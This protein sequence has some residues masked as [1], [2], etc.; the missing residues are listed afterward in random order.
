M[1]IVDLCVLA[2]IG[3][4]VVFGLYQGFL[5]AGL[6]LISFFASW[7]LASTFY[8]TLAAW[9][10]EHTGIADMIFS[11]TQGS[12]YIQD[13]ALAN[14][15]VASLTP[16]QAGAA[17]EIA[18]T[19]PPPFDALIPQ[20]IQ[21][22]VFEALGHASLSDYFDATL[23]QFILNALCFI[24]IFFACT[25]AFW[26]VI[27]IVDAVRKLPVLKFFDTILGGALGLA[28]GVIIVMV[29]FLIAPIVLAVLPVDMVR[30]QIDTSKS[31]PIFYEHNPLYKVIK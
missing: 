11:Y 19:L 7:F 14:A 15:A 23:S 22:M 24:A 27:A 20:N 9:V 31:A 13:P 1:N 6:N 2:I 12:A 21:N 28:R 16:Q 3:V 26:L 30:E 10:T 29:L 4:S 5:V 25:I 17:A 8:K 18:G